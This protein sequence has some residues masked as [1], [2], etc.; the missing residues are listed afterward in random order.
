MR[1]WISLD[2]TAILSSV[3]SLVLAAC[4]GTRLAPDPPSSRS[5]LE[6]QAACQSLVPASQGGPMPTGNVATLRWLGTSNYELAYH[7]KIV[8]MDTFYERPAR[9]AS[10]GFTVG[11]VRKADVRRS[12]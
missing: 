11:S 3:T 12:M 10:L 1:S 5:A 7:G 9:T 4:T 8:I 2:R 6:P